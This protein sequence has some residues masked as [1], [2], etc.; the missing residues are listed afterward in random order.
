MFGLDLLRIER[1]DDFCNLV[2]PLGGAGRSNNN[3]GVDR[4]DF[5]GPATFVFSPRLKRISSEVNAEKP[6]AF[7]SMK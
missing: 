7:T 4:C 6:F 3:V 5:D 2:S 1:R